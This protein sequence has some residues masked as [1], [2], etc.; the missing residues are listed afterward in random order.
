MNPEPPASESRFR[1]WWNWK[2]LVASKFLIGSIA[3]HLLF[4]VGATYYVVQRIQAKRK[5]TFSGGPPLVNASQHALEHKISLAKKK[6]SMSAPAQAKRITTTGLAK[7]A[8]PEMPTMPHATEV[9]PNRMA[10]MGGTGSG[11]GFGSGGVGT[12]GG[13]GGAF[14]LPR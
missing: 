12:G 14:M 9:L 8:L 10:G 4:G 13:G 7:V 3:V 5:M 1:R 2:T 6:A 11:L